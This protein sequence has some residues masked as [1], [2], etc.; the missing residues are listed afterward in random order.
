MAVNGL[1]RFRREAELY[2]RYLRGWQNIIEI[3]EELHQITPDPQVK[4]VIRRAVEMTRGT[5]KFVIEYL[6]KSEAM[7]EKLDQALGEFPSHDSTPD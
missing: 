3:S 5:Q 1:N 4:E 2:R 6:Q 7:F